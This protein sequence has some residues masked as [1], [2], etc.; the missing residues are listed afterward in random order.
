[1][2]VHSLALYTFVATDFKINVVDQDPAKI[3]NFLVSEK[4]CM[5]LIALYIHAWTV[6]VSHTHTQ[7]DRHANRQLYSIRNWLCV[8]REI[9]RE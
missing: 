2:Y 7:A 6:I 9:R 5:Y 3:R 1:M 4:R 8:C